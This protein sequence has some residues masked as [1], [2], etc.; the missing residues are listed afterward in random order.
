MQ[1]TVSGVIM[2]TASINKLTP[3]ANRTRNLLYMYKGV[4]VPPLGMVDDIL[5][6]STCSQQAIA[7]NATVNSFIESKKLQMKQSKCYAIYVG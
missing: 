3:L 6:I 4:R 1:G 2:C 7:M 5:T